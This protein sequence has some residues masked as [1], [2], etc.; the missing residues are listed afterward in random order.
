MKNYTK[1]EILKI[2][3]AYIKK[4]IACNDRK[5]RLK[6][7][8]VNETMQ[9]VSKLK[10]DT[11]LNIMDNANHESLNLGNILEN[12]MVYLK[13]ESENENVDYK[14]LVND[15]ANILENNAKYINIVV[16]KATCKGVFRVLGSEV[17][18]KRLTLNELL[19]CESLQPMETLSK[20]LGLEI[21]LPNE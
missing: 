12:V 5:L 2:E 17:R 15:T 13:K 20:R 16:V 9:L 8:L 3:G 19:A 21:V 7:R 18:N 14:A 4:Y 6:A 11:Y 10:L 1:E